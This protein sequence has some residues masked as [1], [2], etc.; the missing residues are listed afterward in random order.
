MNKFLTFS[1]L[2]IILFSC[3][4]KT[5]DIFGKSS[6]QEVKQGDKIDLVT[7]DQSKNISDKLKEVATLASGTDYAIS[8]VTNKEP[9][10]EVA[11][12]INLRVMSLAGQPDLNSQKEMWKMIDGLLSLNQE[13]RHQGIKDLQ[14]KDE[15]ISKLQNKEMEL[16]IKK[17]QEIDNY[18]KV[19]S[20]T[21]GLA[22]TRKAQLNEYEG[23]FGLKAIFKGLWQFITSSV[24]IIATVLIVFLI[25][26][27]FAAT[28]PVIGAI[29]SIVEQIAAGFMHLIQG[30]APRAAQFA[31]FIPKVTFDGYQQTLNKLIDTIELLKDSQQRTQKVY[32]M[33]ELLMELSK[34]MGDA[35][36]NRIHELK[37]NIGWV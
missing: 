19:A 24:W 25:L 6:K 13:Q 34:N 26:R 5:L 14:K 10:V 18:R 36:K 37:K 20:E 4:C 32:T 8:K 21:A 3:S 2:I 23:W 29:F 12:D 31:N 33:D 1:M 11:Q 16:F 30:I 35:D 28:N 22:D 17:D 7:K 9:A 27:T 15:E